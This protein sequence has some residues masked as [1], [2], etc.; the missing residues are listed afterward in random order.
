MSDISKFKVGNDTY[1]I[2]DEESRN[3]SP[4]T[5]KGN[6]VTF[7]DGIDIAAKNVTVTI[8]PSQEGTGDPSP[9][10]V[11]PLIGFDEVDVDVTGK[12]L[13]NGKNVYTD[14]YVSDVSF[15]IP[16][17]GYYRDIFTA[18]YGQ[19]VRVPQEYINKLPFLNTGTYTISWENS[20]AQLCVNKVNTD[21]TAIVL[22]DWFSSGD[23]I[24]LTEPS[25]I[26]MRRRDSNAAETF[27]NLQ[28]EKGA[29]ATPYEPFGT[30]TPISLGRTVY[31]GVLDVTNGKLTLTYGYQQF[32]GTEE[33]IS[34]L[35]GVFRL[36]VSPIA[37][38]WSTTISNIYKSRVSAAA[39]LPNSCVGNDGK[40]WTIYDE[41]DPLYGD[42]NAYKT[43]LAQLYADGTPLEVAYPL[44]TPEVIDLTPTEIDMLLGYN[45]ISTNG[46]TLSLVYQP[47]N[48]LG[49]AEKY[50]DDKVKDYISKRDSQ[51]V[52]GFHIDGNESDP[53]A[54]VTYLADAIG[55]TPAHMDY[56]K[57]VFDYGSWKDAFFMPKLVML[58]QDGT[59]DCYLDPNDDSKK[60][61]GTDSHAWHL[62]IVETSTTAA[63]A[64]AVDDYFVLGDKLYQTTSAIA[65]GDTIAEG[66]N[67]IEI[68]GVNVHDNVMI[69]WGQRG[70]KIW[71]KI[72]PSAD[73]ESCD[74]F[75]SDSQVDDGYNDFAFHNKNG[76]SMD[77]FYTPAYNGSLVNDVLRSLPDMKAMN[78]K[79]A[80]QERTYA[81]AN[82]SDMW[83]M[84]KK[85]DIDLI[86]SLLV[87]MGRST[88]TQAVFGEGLHTGGTSQIDN[89]F[90]TG[91][92][93]TKGM[94]YGTNSGTI[95]NGSYGNAVKVFFM[96]NWWGFQWR[97][98]LGHL[99]VSGIQK[100]KLTY[101]TEDGSTAE[102]FDFTG[103]NYITIG[104]TPSGTS[105]GYI[106]KMYFAK[107][108]AFSR[109]A[110]GTATTQYCD[111]QWYSSLYTRVP[112]RG[113]N[114]YNGSSVGAFS[115]ALDGEAKDVRWFLGAALSCKP[116]A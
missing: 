89:N 74:V 12:N 70:K 27:N 68:T 40:V 59:V 64:H 48:V 37:K 69:E 63:I 18:L 109:V 112:L 98:Y 90:R 32:D 9:E 92:H 73:H 88:N 2:K 82:G 72:V 55:M 83:D 53:E 76:V 17:G 93:S 81:Q 26:T 6:P 115:M 15:T 80:T 102:G 43:Y 42:V 87:L 54:K 21:G 65:I 10:N 45:T 57:G 44:A 46:T 85:V 105:G 99:L 114:S 7:S 79:T 113:G 52:Y 3:T 75:I 34:F 110:S 36:G 51:I 116:L 35:S 31:G 97:R 84:E 104:A 24:T 106:S 19:R 25:R 60:L 101:G 4:K 22:K 8:E 111:G 14:F 5:I 100:V 62:G 38:N 1:N 47:N 91:V 50:T 56:E 28:I 95:A 103:S 67:C 33:N 20:E 86:N 39:S 66:I 49:V 16:S 58:K 77:H 96:E 78:S 94:F 71:S 30:S 23:T 107:Q 29:T 11:R 61:D 108:G 13:F 41:D